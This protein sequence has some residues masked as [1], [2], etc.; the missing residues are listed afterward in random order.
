MIRY[1]VLREHIKEKG[2]F[3]KNY[4]I[5]NYNITIIKYYYELRHNI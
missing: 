5:Y 1:I 2:V 4:L 3:E